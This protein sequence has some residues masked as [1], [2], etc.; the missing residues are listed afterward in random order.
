MLMDEPLSGLDVNSQE[1]TFH[2][3][4]ELS[5]RE[6]TLLVAMHDLKLAAKHFERVMLLN[7]QLVA[8]GSPDQVFEPQT[9]TQAYSAHLHLVAT[10][11]GMLALGDTCCDDGEYHS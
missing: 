7:R 3:L 6:V 4:E 11:D 8:L 5:R 10:D 2:I 9:L 1:D